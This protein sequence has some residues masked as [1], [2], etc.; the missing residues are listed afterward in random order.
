MPE[1]RVRLSA[2][3]VGDFDDDEMRTERR[4]GLERRRDVV[5]DHHVWPEERQADE[6]DVTVSDLDLDR[7]IDVDV[8]LRGFGMST[9]WRMRTTIPIDALSTE[10]F[11]S[12]KR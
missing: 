9:V 1:R 4:L 7:R 3:V 6:C 12:K 2:R 10:S 11:R 5:L 8:E